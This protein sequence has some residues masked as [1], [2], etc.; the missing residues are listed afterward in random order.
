MIQ[1]W[2]V[3]NVSSVTLCENYFSY[4]LEINTKLELNLQYLSAL[5]QLTLDDEF[6]TDVAFF[7]FFS[8]PVLCHVL[9]EFQSRKKI[10]GKIQ[11][12]FFFR[13][14]SILKFDL[15]KLILPW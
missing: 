11:N 5:V 6:C 14:H 10:I 4:L 9:M 15:P 7:S 8:S 1:N 2:I 13:F 3:I 12:C